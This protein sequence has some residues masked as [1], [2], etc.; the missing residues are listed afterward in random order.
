MFTGVLFEEMEVGRYQKI[1]IRKNN[2][3]EIILSSFSRSF[4][5]LICCS[6]KPKSDE[7]LLICCSWELRKTAIVK[8]FSLYLL[9]SVHVS[10]N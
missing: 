4:L 5:L 8:G 1:S 3:G 6:K 10:V 2:F 7:L 9:L